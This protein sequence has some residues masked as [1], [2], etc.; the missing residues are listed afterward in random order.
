ML[1]EQRLIHTSEIMDSDRSVSLLSLSIIFF[2]RKKPHLRAEY[3][4][5][6]VWLLIISIR[7]RAFNLQQ[8]RIHNVICSFAGRLLWG[9]KK[10]GDLFVCD[11]TNNVVYAII[12]LSEFKQKG[13]LVTRY[14]TFTV[15]LRV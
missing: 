13:L 3:K 9:V 2:S 14:C 6:C 8:S 7:L 1:R 11:Y 10:T 5:L 15:P 12:G 4:T